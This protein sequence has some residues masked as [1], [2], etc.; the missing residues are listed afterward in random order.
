M[1][2]SI[3]NEQGETIAKSSDL[4]KELPKDLATAEVIK[5]KGFYEDAVKKLA[6]FKDENDDV[7]S[8]FSALKKVVNLTKNNYASALIQYYEIT[9]KEEEKVNG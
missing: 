5:A 7:L 8:E 4:P 3:L 1:D 6:I 9:N 2:V